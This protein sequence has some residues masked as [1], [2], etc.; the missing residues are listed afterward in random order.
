MTNSDFPYSVAIRTLGKAGE[1]F[2][3][4]LVSLHRQT[5]S[6]RRI[7]VYIA[8]GCSRPGFTI[9]REEYV[10]VKKGMVTQR[11]LPYTEVSTPYLLLL[12]DDVSLPDDGVE[13]LARAMVEKNADCVAPDVFHPQDSSFAQTAYS[14]L[15][16]RALPRL[17]ND[18]WAFKIRRDCSFSYP[19]RP[20]DGVYRSQSASGPASLWRKDALLDIRLADESWLDRLGFAYGEDQLLFY[21]LVRNG[22][23]LLVH[24]GAGFQHLDAQTSRRDYS[25]KSDRL[26][27][28]MMIQYLLWRRTQQDASDLSSCDR[29]RSRLAWGFKVVQGASVHLAY[30]ILKR[31]RR[32]L[33]MFRDG[34]REGRVFAL[35]QEYK[36]IPNFIV[37]GR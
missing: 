28:R 32:I 20:G 14:Y 37:K 18:G 30:A 33:Q 13:R 35:S 34:L 24:Y 21:K 10:Q 5:I 4:E 7:L 29:F 31:D 6:P 8:E 1:K 3:Q 23:S 22:G 25:A 27:L 17:F 26:K 11:A 36:E 12:D 9:G 15:T 16:N 2:R 19:L